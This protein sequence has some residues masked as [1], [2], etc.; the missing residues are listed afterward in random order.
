MSGSEPQSRSTP[1]AAARVPTL[2]AVKA[3]Q[4]DN[5][6]HMRKMIIALTIVATLIDSL[7]Y[8]LDYRNGARFDRQIWFD[9]NNC[10]RDGCDAECVRGP[11]VNDLRRFYL[12]PGISKDDVVRI[13]GEFE[14]KHKQENGMFCAEYNLGMCSGFRIDYDALVVCFGGDGRLAQTW[15]E[16]H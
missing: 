7:L 6:V 8:L 5:G 9:A 10:G 11:M 3:R 16:Q 15:T 4:R 2:L 14:Q 12:L 13:V 1:L